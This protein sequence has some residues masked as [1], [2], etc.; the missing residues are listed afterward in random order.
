MI[1]CS[2]CSV[3]ISKVEV[4]ERIAKSGKNIGNK[5]KARIC[6]D[7]G[8]FNF[9]NEHTSQGLPDEVMV[10]LKCIESK[11][12]QVLILLTPNDKVKFIDGQ[13]VINEEDINWNESGM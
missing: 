13:P 11:L 7:C 6:S 4:I 9:V 2:N 1:T 12:E 8:T 5:Y 10:H 3:D